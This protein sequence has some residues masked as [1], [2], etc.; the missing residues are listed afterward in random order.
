ML[1][2]LLFMSCIRNPLEFDIDENAFFAISVNTG[3]FANRSN[4]KIMTIEGVINIYL[5][6][7]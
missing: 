2:K 7:F 6:L 1:E 4:L 5:S 3:L